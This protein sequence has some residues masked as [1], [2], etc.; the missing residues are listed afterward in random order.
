MAKRVWGYMAMGCG[1][2][3]HTSFWYKRYTPMETEIDGMKIW[4]TPEDPNDPTAGFNITDAN[5]GVKICTAECT[6]INDIP[7]KIHKKLGIVKAKITDPNYAEYRERCEWVADLM[8]FV[9]QFEGPNKGNLRT[10][11]EE[12]DYGTV[13]E[14]WSAKNVHEID[15]EGN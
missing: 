15:A 9:S 11:P 3:R 10:P 12:I 5:S 8:K 6:E 14:T 2:D 1:I 4:Y 13:F 7:K